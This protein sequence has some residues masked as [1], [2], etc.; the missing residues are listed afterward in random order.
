[1][2]EAAADL[3]LQLE[4]DD[5]AFAAELREWLDEHLP[6]DRPP[7]DP[8]ERIAWLRC[9]QAELDRGRW[10]AVAWPEEHGGRAATPVQQL[11]YHLEMSQR[12][13]PMVVGQ[14]GLNLCG[15]TLVAHGSEAQRRR[16]LAP[17][18]SGQE[19]WAQAFSEPGAGSD[20]ASLRTRGV[21]DGD[22]LV[23][24]GQ[25][26]WTT[27][28]HIADW[29][30]ALVRTDPAAPKREGL[31]FVLVPLDAAG[32]TV[33]PIR[34][35]SGDAEFNEVFLDEVRVPLSNVVGGL[36]QGWQVTRTT[37]A[38]ERAVLF[39]G[40]QLA[41]RSLV[42]RIVATAQTPGLD[43]SRAA[44]DPGLRKRIAEAWITSRLVGVNGMRNLGR[45]LAGEEPGPEGAMSKLFGQEAE[46]R[47]HELALDVG[48]L[49]ALLDRGAVDAHGGGRWA[50]GWLRTRASTIGGGTSEI[51][52]NILAER[53]LGQPRDPWSDD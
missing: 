7:R 30:F 23:I 45:V 14:I 17:M 26:V 24:T 1:V 22:E 11:L 35:I 46:Q 2:S 4:P 6:A 28:A 19:L 42:D 33:R 43:G 9:W 31:S 52:R 10:V 12:R 5:V 25:K 48:G 29:L 27:G 40:Q 32:I 53:V 8:E 47:I 36:G 21:V 44:D 13:A 15:P 41:L 50:L 18:R 3:G 34:Q 39:T 16:H 20:L 51:Q 37:L 49:G 38:N